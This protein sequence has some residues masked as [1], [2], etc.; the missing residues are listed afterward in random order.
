MQI[1]TSAWWVHP[2]QVSKTAPSGEYL[3]TGSFMIR[4]KKNFLPPSQLIMGFAYMFKV[5]PT[6]VANHV[7]ERAVRTLVDC[8]QSI[9]ISSLL[10]LLA[11]RA[12]DDGTTASPLISS[13]FCSQCQNWPTRATMTLRDQ[14]VAVA[15]TKKRRTLRFQRRD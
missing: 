13:F 14:L 2:D 1:P 9:S 6:S 8:T 15:M 7:N 5:D 4:G 10:L 12:N 3:V 11:H